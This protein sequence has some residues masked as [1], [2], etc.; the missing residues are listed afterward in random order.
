MIKLNWE[1]GAQSERTIYL[2]IDSIIKKKE[3]LSLKHLYEQMRGAW[4][5]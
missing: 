3:T 4:T 2:Y 5:T 1:Q